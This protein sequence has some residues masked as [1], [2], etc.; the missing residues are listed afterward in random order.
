MQICYS[1][2]ITSIQQISMFAG[3]REP[4][5]AKWQKQFASC[6]PPLYP[7]LQMPLIAPQR[8][9]QLKYYCTL[10]C[11]GSPV[12]PNP[13]D[14]LSLNDLYTANETCIV[15]GLMSRRSPPAQ[16]IAARF[17]RWRHL[18]RDFDVLQVES[19]SGF[20]RHTACFN[21]SEAAS[22]RSTIRSCATTNLPRGP[23]I[24]A[25][26]LALKACPNP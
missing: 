9:S 2:I 20:T 25:S 4:R 15:L 24:A 10:L 21:V 12:R 7:Q 26:A 5:T 6:P 8:V 13:K 17:L 16:E 11:C 18:P 3:D 22:G 1:R 23:C 14:S 19:G